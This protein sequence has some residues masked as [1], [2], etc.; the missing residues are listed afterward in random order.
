MISEQNEVLNFNRK[1]IVQAQFNR[2]VCSADHHD[3]LTRHQTS[4]VYFRKTS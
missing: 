1:N 3:I 4:Q 2:S